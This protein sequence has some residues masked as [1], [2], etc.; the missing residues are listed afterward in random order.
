MS[1]SNADLISLAAAISP[2]PGPGPS[3]VW[4]HCAHKN[5]LPALLSATPQIKISVRCPFTIGTSPISAFKPWWC[6][7]INSRQTGAG[8]VLLGNSWTI[9]KSALEYNGAFA[10]STYGGGSRSLVMA[11]GDY[12]VNNAN[13]LGDAV[14]MS[15]AFGVSTIPVG[16]TAWFRF[17]ARVPIAG[18]NMPVGRLVESEIAGMIAFWHTVDGDVSEIDG[19]GILVGSG[20]AAQVTA[21]CYPAPIALGLV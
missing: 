15:S 17:R 19:T 13:C 16:D 7:F 1:Y 2:P 10:F 4:R 12:P 14:T 3:N 11:S 20:G 9:E 5:K 21:Q 18:N 8:E 6:A